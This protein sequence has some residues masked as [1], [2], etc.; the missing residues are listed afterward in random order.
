MAKKRTARQ[1][2]TKLFVLDASVTLVW[3]FEDETDDY[4]E[5]VA[6]S[7]AEVH[8]VT[9]GLW[10]LEVANSLLVGERRKRTTEAKVA[11]FLGLLQTLPI[12]VDE[13]TSL[14][15]WQDTLR[16]ARAHSLSVYDATYLELALRRGLPLATID[17]RLKSAAAAVG[18][19]EF[20]PR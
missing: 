4:A 11:Q 15:A 18:V 8:A 6:D 10:H 13:E 1:P 20:T 14:R 16:L 5:A 2:K 3:A 9:P 19:V 17:D 7:L 12:S